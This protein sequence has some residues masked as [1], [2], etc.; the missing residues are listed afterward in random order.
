MLCKEFVAAS[1]KRKLLKIAEKAH[2][3]LSDTR[4][5]SVSVSRVHSCGNSTVRIRSLSVKAASSVLR[6]GE[7]VS[8]DSQLDLGKVLD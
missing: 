8:I 2:V 7:S 6:G 4:S 1:A 3:C 5:I